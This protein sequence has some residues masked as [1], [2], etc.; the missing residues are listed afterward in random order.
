MKRYWK[1]ISLC[2]VTGIV[3]G[4]FYIQSSL[5]A[6]ENVKIEFERINGNQDEVSNLILFGDYNV[7][8]LNQYLYFSNKETIN[9]NNISFIDQFTK[10]SSNPMM[11]DL[12]EE[13]RNFM[14]SK[15]LVPNFF[16]EDDSLLVYADINKKKSNGST[17]NFKFE[18]E[19]L[20]KKSEEV[21]S[22]NLE[23]PEKEKYISMGVVDVQVIGD[24]IKIITRNFGMEGVNELNV[25]EIDIA[26]QKLVNDETIVKTPRVENGWSDI[27]IHNE[28]NS[29]KPQKYLLLK[30]SIEEDHMVHENGETE[31]NDNKSNLADNEVIIYNIETNQTKKITIPDEINRYLKL[32]MSTIV[33]ST[34]YV[35]SQLTD[36]F[37]VSQYNIEREEWGKKMT[38]NLSHLENTEKQPPRVRLIDGKIIVI[39]SAKNGNTIFIGDLTTGKSL[40]EGNLIVKKSGEVQTDGSLFI[41]Q[42]DYIQ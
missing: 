36:G 41:H 4:T 31:Q 37:E 39:S 40:Y 25:Y 19:I 20:N 35:Q 5:A 38:F 24:K 23:I 7:G 33:N 42:I 17:R 26:K 29:L 27:R 18:I 30:I 8:N 9:V 10:V 6:K 14:R 34:I 1:I 2:I 11:E 12:V 15:V 16:F 3:I 32:G 28:S 13:H 21:T 22:I